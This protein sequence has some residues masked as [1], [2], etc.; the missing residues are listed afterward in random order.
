MSLSGS[1]GTATGGSGRIA[2]TS[3]GGLVASGF[4]R[5]YFDAA[6]SDIYCRAD[7]SATALGARIVGTKSF[8]GAESTVDPVSK[9]VTMSKAY[10][11]VVS[12]TLSLG[13]E[14]TLNKQ[15]IPYNLHASASTTPSATN[16]YSMNLSI[17]GT[18]L[19]SPQSVT[20]GF[21]QQMVTKRRVYNPLEDKRVQFIA[22]YIDVGCEVSRTADLTSIAAGVAWQPNKNLLLKSK[23]SSAAGVSVTAACKS[24]WSPTITAAVTA[25]LSHSGPY[26]GLQLKIQNTGITDYSV[27]D[28]LDRETGYRWDTVTETTRFNESNRLASPSSSKHLLV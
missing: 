13:G 16:R 10:G 17:S 6:A 7:E 14:V 15:S 20:I 24:W 27:P 28:S 2:I 19:S 23:I 22:N 8:F 12:D 18:G 26:T 21:I 5:R 4:L 25:G 1:I 3:Q 9:N 11:M